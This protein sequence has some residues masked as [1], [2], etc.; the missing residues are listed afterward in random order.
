[1][2]KSYTTLTKD[3]LCKLK[4]SKD[5][6]LL[7]ELS[8]FAFSSGNIKLGRGT[9]VLQLSSENENVIIRIASI[10]K[11]LYNAFPEIRKVEKNQ[12]KKHT[13]YMMDIA[14]SD[15]TGQMLFEIGLLAGVAEDY[16]F[17]SINKGVFEPE[18]CFEASLRG[19]FLGCGVLCDPSKSYRLEFVLSHDE[20]AEFLYTSLFERGMQAK[21]AHRKERN[22][23]FFEQ[24]EYVGDT[25]IMAG[26]TNTMMMIESISVNKAMMNMMNR[27]SNCIVANIKKA[28]N[29]SQKQIEDINALY[30]AGVKLT[31][32]LK[33]ACELRLNNPDVSLNEL[34]KISGISKSALNKR[35]IKIRQMREKL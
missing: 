33:E 16:S 35:F 27:S 8:A 20:F 7:A 17:G 10:I 15:Q 24:I 29:A 12:P 22:V 4:F 19:A 13:V 6:H 9:L 21:F 34:E 25:L 28:V 30:N 3:E 1:M 26:A 2:E 11:R 31:K 32:P 23:I 14:P 18:G 5:T